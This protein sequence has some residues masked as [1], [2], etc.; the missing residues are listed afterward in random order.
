M[1]ECRVQCNSAS[2]SVQISA[3]KYLGGSHLLFCQ[4]LSPFSLLGSGFCLLPLPTEA[5]RRG[6]SESMGVRLLAIPSPNPVTLFHRFRPG[7]PEDQDKSRE[8][9]EECMRL[10]RCPPIGTSFQNTHP[11][12]QKRLPFYW[13]ISSR[14]HT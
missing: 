6:G 2:L 10:P 12:K 4:C 13:F 11:S 9:P 7:D 3:V 14:K 5:E 1:V 8:P